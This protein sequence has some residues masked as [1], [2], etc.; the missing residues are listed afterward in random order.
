M[1]VTMTGEIVSAIVG[2]VISLALEIVP[3]L[4]SLW[5]KWEWKRGATLLLCLAAGFATMGLCY[6]GAPVGFECAGPFIWDGLFTAFKA[7]FAAYFLN[8]VTY[9][10]VSRRVAMRH[11]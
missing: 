2:T 5:D 7:S 10:V 6:A 9:A 8:Q 11:K 4:A 3:G 1:E